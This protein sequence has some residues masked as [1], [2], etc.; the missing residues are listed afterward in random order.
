MGLKQL[1]STEH[2]FVLAV[3]VH[4]PQTEVD[5]ACFGLD[6]QNLVADDRYMTFFNQPSTPCGGISLAA[7]H[8]AV[9]GFEFKFAAHP[10]RNCPYCVG[11]Y[12][13]W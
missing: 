3:K 9:E 1:V 10:P 5:C 7:P 8:D 6:L 12:I 13:G 4:I 11:G 2:P